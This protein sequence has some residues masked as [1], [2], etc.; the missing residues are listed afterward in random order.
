[1]KYGI[2]YYVNASNGSLTYETSDT[3]RV[4]SA[5]DSEG[6]RFSFEY[7]SRGNV[8]K[9]TQLHTNDPT[10]NLEYTAGFDSTCSYPAKCNKRNWVRSPNGEQTDFIYD[11]SHGG[12][13]KE[14]LPADPQA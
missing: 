2:T 3:N 11:V 4:V 9:K 12:L 14:T 5:V 10:Q 13:L 1:M 6:R 8:T 7:D